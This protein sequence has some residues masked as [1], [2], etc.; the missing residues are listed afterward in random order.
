M[1]FAPDGKFRTIVSILILT[2]ILLNAVWISAKVAPCGQVIAR[3]NWPCPLK[4]CK[5]VQGDNKFMLG[6][7]NCSL[8]GKLL[9]PSM[10]NWFRKGSGGKIGGKFMLMEL[11]IWTVV[12]TLKPLRKFQLMLTKLNCRNIIKVVVADVAEK[13][14]LL[15]YGK[16]FWFL[17]FFEF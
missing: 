7:W 15:I 14:A 3:T 13:A 12:R 16:M 2:G 17:T 9:T 4:V 6:H 8:L 1:T 11:K 10:R 5:H